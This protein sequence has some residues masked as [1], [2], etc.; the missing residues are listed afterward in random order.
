[1]IP[2]TPAAPVTFPV[3]N[4]LV[5]LPLLSPAS[6][7]A[8]PFDPHAHR[9]AGT[10]LAGAAELGQVRDGSARD[11]AKVLSGEPADQA[12]RA[13]ADIARRRRACDRCLIAGDKPTHSAAVAR[14]HIS[15][16]RRRTE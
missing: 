4:A 13:A 6:P 2:P 15:R 10:R 11:R 3:A 16:A 9:A 1:M 8:V 12:E 14:L 5:M 7:P